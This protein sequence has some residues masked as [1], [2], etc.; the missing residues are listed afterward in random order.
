MEINRLILLLF[1]LLRSVSTITAVVSFTTNLD[2]DKRY[3]V[4]RIHRLG[5]AN[6][7]RCI[8]DWHQ[9]AVRS[10]RHLLVSWAPTYD[11]N[12]TFPGLFIAGPAGKSCEVTNYQYDDNV[13]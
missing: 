10:D 1:L 9:I 11:C 12:I 4:V 2:A 8:A 3:L 5:L 13:Y 7:L 6:R